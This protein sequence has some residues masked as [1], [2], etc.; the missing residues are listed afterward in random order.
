MAIKQLI[1]MFLK[2][3]YVVEC[4]ENLKRMIVSRVKS[5]DS[6]IK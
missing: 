2:A 4:T 3:F 1:F 5:V 6:A